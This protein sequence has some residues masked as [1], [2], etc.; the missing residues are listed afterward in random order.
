VSAESHAKIAAPS[1]QSR[2]SEI[3]VPQRWVDRLKTHLPSS[4]G[5]PTLFFVLTALAQW[6]F[7]GQNESAWDQVTS[8]AF[9][10]S[11]VAIVVAGLVLAV[12]HL[13]C[14][15]F[16]VLQATRGKLRRAEET[17]A[18]MTEA[19][20][21]TLVSEEHQVRLVAL[22]DTCLSAF[23]NERVCRFGDRLMGRPFQ[24]EMFEA[25][26]GGHILREMDLWSG[27]VSRCNAATRN[28]R[29]RLVSEIRSRGLDVPPFMSEPIE[30]M[31][32]EALTR[33]WEAADD[34]GRHRLAWRQQDTGASTE[35]SAR[36][37]WW[38]EFTIASVVEEN[39]MSGLME[40][41]NLVD[42]LVKDAQEWPE[43]REMVD[44]W[45][46]L[47]DFPSEWLCDEI[48]ARKFAPMF[49]A[50]G[51]LGCGLG[52]QQADESQARAA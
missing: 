18:E 1:S 16:Q 25:H 34:W 12:F 35:L 52:D 40:T 46:E 48:L 23:D 42:G 39:D 50:P 5:I 43:A 24:R 8:G 38:N 33:S 27:I 13:V 19:R 49:A 21:A 45:R 51:C 37:P 32:G 14:V 9:L 2:L 29:R 41:M 47:H 31:L 20:A 28:F 10:P 17:I 36:L 22:L 30:S 3:G 26:F 4:V 6:E 15:Y 11:I 44:A 7:D